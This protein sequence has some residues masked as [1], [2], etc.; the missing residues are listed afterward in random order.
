MEEI[1]DSMEEAK[2]CKGKPSVIIARTIKG[3]GVAFME[4]KFEWHARAPTADELQKALSEL[5]R[6]EEV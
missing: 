6:S 5:D 3:K 4:H 1:I 2:A